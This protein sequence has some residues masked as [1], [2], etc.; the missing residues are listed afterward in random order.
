[1]C[2]SIIENYKNLEKIHQNERNKSRSIYFYLIG[3]SLFIIG[4]VINLYI[5][6]SSSFEDI[7]FINGILN[8]LKKTP[9]LDLVLKDTYDRPDYDCECKE[10]NKI[11]ITKGDCSEEK[12]RLNCDTFYI[13]KRDFN[14]YRNKIF[15]VKRDRRRY[16]DSDKNMIVPKNKKCPKGKKQCGILDSLGNILCLNDNELCPLNDII[17]NNLK[18]MKDYKSQELNEGKYIHTNKSIKNPIIS[19]LAIFQKDPCF[20]SQEYVWET[21]MP[22]ERGKGSGC[23]KSKDR[24]DER[25]KYLDTYNLSLLYD[26]NFIYNWYLDEIT[27]KK[28]NL[29]M[30]LKFIFFI[31]IILD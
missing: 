2:K 22:N 18:T 16:Y 8:D 11:E 15:Y 13:I 24:K 1:M 4:S 10:D 31:E 12:K 14:K 9:I 26:E 23:K 29:F 17:I 3:I 27:P 20:Y 21:F 25:Y 30:T 7:N 28:K 19:D 5:Y 6:D